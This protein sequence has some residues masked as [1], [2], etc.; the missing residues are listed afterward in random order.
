MVNRNGKFET[1]LDQG[2]L[3]D[4]AVSACVLKRKKEEEEEED[5]KINWAN[6]SSRT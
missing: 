4:S 6:V 1:R 3:L 2:T 5:K